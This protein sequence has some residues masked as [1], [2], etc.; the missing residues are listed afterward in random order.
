MHWHIR[1]PLLVHP[2]DL[3]TNK[4]PDL[5]FSPALLAPKEVGD[6]QCEPC[7]T[8]P[9]DIF[10]ALPSSCAVVLQHEAGPTSIIKEP[11]NVDGFLA[12]LALEDGARLLLGV[13]CEEKCRHQHSTVPQHHC[14]SSKQNRVS[15]CALCT[16]PAPQSG[17][18]GCRGLWASLTSTDQCWCWVLLCRRRHSRQDALLPQMQG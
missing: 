6:E 2:V 4:H 10:S 3:P 7:R 16:N 9:Q 11:V 12:L 1:L 17:S 8:Q 18:R 13:C 5:A 15:V 14:Y